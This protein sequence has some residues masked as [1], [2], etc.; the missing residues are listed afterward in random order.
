LNHKVN[1]STLHS[2][3]FTIRERKAKEHKENVKN[4]LVNGSDLVSSLVELYNKEIEKLTT[5]YLK[6]SELDEDLLKELNVDVKNLLNAF[7]EKIEGLKNLYWQEIFNNLDS[8]TTRLTSR[9][10]ESLLNTLMS[11]T[12]IDFTT[13]NVRSVVIWVIKNSSKYFKIFFIEYI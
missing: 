12:N 2:S 11:N 4:A 7:K 6:V 8:I 1:G 9:T 13:S 5:N 10:R 3:D